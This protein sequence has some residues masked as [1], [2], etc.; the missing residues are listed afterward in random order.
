MIYRSKKTLHKFDNSSEQGSAMVI[1]LLVMILLMAFVA[2]AI[3]RTNSET[4]AA[5]NDE[6][7]TKT[8][9]A[10][11][12]SLEIMT[13]NFNKIFETKLNPDS[14]DIPHIQGEYPPGFTADYDYTQTLTQTQATQEVVMTGEMFQGLN[15][16]RDE[17][18]LDTTATAHND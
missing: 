16:L 8:F 2:L 5:S 6:S 13:R 11:H 15:A 7:E 10:A 3:S 9:E 12:A 1:A 14:T 18:Q 4:I 17:W